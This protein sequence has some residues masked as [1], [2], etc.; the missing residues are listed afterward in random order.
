MSL[1]LVDFII[2]SFRACALETFRRLIY[3]IMSTLASTMA[4][5]VCSYL[6]ARSVWRGEGPGDHCCF[7]KSTRFHEQ[8]ENA[9]FVGCTALPTEP[10]SQRSLSGSVGRAV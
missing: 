7:K 9:Y 3:G 10:L 8:L 4:M 2:C 1:I 5:I 6:D